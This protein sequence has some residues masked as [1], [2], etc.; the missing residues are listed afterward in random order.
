MK[1]ETGSRGA[2][3]K[4]KEWTFMATTNDMTIKIAGAAGQGLESSGA[5]FVQAL[6][7]G[8]LHIYGL[9]DYMSRIR[10][11]LNFFQVRVHDQPL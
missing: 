4:P 2:T 7:L 1:A 3:Q 8:G 5:G 6:A 11:G 9:Q 10:G